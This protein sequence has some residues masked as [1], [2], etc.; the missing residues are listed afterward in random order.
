MAMH[1]PVGLMEAKVCLQQLVD[2]WL[3]WQGQLSMAEEMCWF[4]SGLED[5]QEGASPAD[6]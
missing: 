2:P 1:S 6:A 5:W 3:L 4:Q